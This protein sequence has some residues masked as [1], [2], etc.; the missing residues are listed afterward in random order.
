MAF[1]LSLLIFAAVFVLGE[2]LRPKPKIENAKPAALGEFP[3]PTATEGRPI[4]VIWGT[5]RIQGA[6]VTW[7]G[8]FQQR[9]IK[10]KV[11]SGLFSS[12]RITTG[13]RYYIGIMFALCRG[14][15]DFFRKIWIADNLVW[16]VPFAG[17]TTFAIEEE[18][19]FGGVELGAGGIIG[20]MES[21]DGSTTQPVS[22]YLANFQTVSGD[23]PAYRNVAYITNSNAGNSLIKGK[24][25]VYIGTSTQP[26]VWKFE[27]QRTP[28]GPTGYLAANKTVN[29]LDANPI[30]V[31]YELMTNDDFGLGWSTS[32]ID[33]TSFNTA[34]TT[35]KAEGNGFSFMLDVGEQILEVIRLVEEQID[36]V[37]YQDP[38]DGLWKVALARSDYDPATIPLIDE[39][40]CSDLMNFT[41]GTWD[42]TINTVRVPFSQAVDTFKNTYALAQDMANVQ[43]Q[44]G[45]SLAEVKFPGVKDAD[46]ANSLAWRELRALSRPLAKCQAVVNRTFWDAKPTDVFA[47]SDADLGLTRLSMRVAKVD[48]A[49]LAD[50][51]ITLDLV[52]DVFEQNDGAFGAPPVTVWA[53]PSSVLVPFPSTEQLAF[54]APRALVVRDTESSSTDNKIWAAGRF[55]AVEVDFSMVARTA[56]VTP[57]GAYTEVG[58]ADEFMLI[59]ELDAALTADSSFPLSAIDIVTTPDSQAEIQAAFTAS[60]TT[61]EA[62][63]NLINLLYVGGEFMIVQGTATDLGAD[64]RLTNVYRGVLDSVMMDHSAGAP[65]YLLFAGGNL[66]DDLFTATW[67]VDL[68]LLPRTVDTTVAE[69]DATTIQIQMADRVRRPYPPCEL[70]LS[71]SRFASTTSLEGTGSGFQG[72]GVG[73]E[74][75]RRSMFTSDEI[76]ALTADAATLDPNYPTLYNNT[77]TVEVVDDPDG[78]PVTLFTLDLVQ[79]I[80]GLLLRNT[81]LRHTDGV[82]P[83]RMQVK[84]AAFHDFEGTNYESTVSLD[85]SFDVTTS[86]TGDFNFGALDTNDVSNS[87]TVTD[88]GDH[89][90]ALGV[91]TAVG[92]VEYRLNGGSWT[93]LIAQGAT[94]GTIVGASVSD[95]IEVRH[96]STDTDM[97]TFL[98]MQGP[99]TGDDGYGILF[100]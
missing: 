51:R 58:Q 7:Y 23:T 91:A 79:E 87:Y 76:L 8:D 78:T 47:V 62:G 39:S 48:F 56:A 64:V 53:P 21:F 57:S 18:N 69:G 16:S 12:S 72:V 40:N 74:L 86:L 96:A 41:R 97:E 1:F 20:T 66:T 25:A 89:V 14:K 54:E 37:F 68:K 11:K 31:V 70:D 6:N 59:G 22:D 67:V 94:A 50:G 55:Q 3:F 81:I 93:Q 45:V 98:E 34:A 24:K 2:V 77:H 46:L 61:E 19:L 32:L 29:T 15:V 9:A 83:T 35:L 49:E 44:G 36:G 85:W 73:I 100:T 13:Y 75:V 95:T 65:V 82:L 30:F 43:L 10:K 90:F 71:A 84:V 92:D 4:P 38:A 27:V 80:D 5:V 26:A 63:L 88:A 33:A 42:D 99:G 28:V 17:N 60:P 52:E